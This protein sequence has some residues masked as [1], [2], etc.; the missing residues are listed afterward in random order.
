MQMKKEP[1]ERVC[2]NCNYFFS[3]RAEAS[4]YGICLEDQDFEPFIDELLENLNYSCCQELIEAKEFPGDS[5][6][7]DKYEEAEMIEIDDDFYYQYTENDSNSLSEGDIFTTL[8][9]D[10]NWRRYWKID[11]DKKFD[12]IKNTLT[13]VAPSDS[14]IDSGLGEAV[15]NM[16]GILL[17]R[18]QYGQMLELENLIY[19]REIG[20]P[21]SDMHYINYYCLGIH[22]FN[23]DTASVKRCLQ[24]FIDDPVKSIDLLTPLLDTLNYYGY[25]EIAVQISQEVYHRVRDSDELVEGAEDDFGRTVL[26]NEFQKLYQLKEQQTLASR[27]EPFKRLA[28]Y[29]YVN[30]D[31]LNTVLN[32]L[33]NDTNCS[34]LSYQDFKTDGR[35]FYHALSTRFCKYAFEEKGI[36]FPTAYDIFMGAWDSFSIE[37]AEENGSLEM[38]LELNQGNFDEYICGRFDFLSNKKPHAVAVLWGMPYVYDF[39]I[40]NQLVSEEIALQA[41]QLITEM[42]MD[43]IKGQGDSIWEYTFVHSW[44]RPDSIGEEDFLKEKAYFERTFSEIVDVKDFL[45]A[46]Y[47][48]K[49]LQHN[50]T[51]T[52]RNE[53]CP[54]GSGKKFKKCC[55]Q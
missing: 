13:A 15:V 23:R 4:E 18:K 25:S 30:V 51:K 31:E 17:R 27:E 7:C 34:T 39:L 21:D 36:N 48:S 2:F 40:N 10:E 42:K 49:S 55:G 43:L 12:F 38:I 52:G 19:S 24:S 47:F 16:F 35:D 50:E 20:I 46:E 8:T 22:L 28:L 9:D 44:S 33:L 1:L 37:E 3:S 29:G 14:A 26:M 32:Y 41:L 11:D 45:P 5:D 6:A 53:P 54:C